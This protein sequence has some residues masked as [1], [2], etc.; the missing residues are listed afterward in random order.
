MSV[1]CSDIDR[2]RIMAAAQVPLENVTQ[3]TSKP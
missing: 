2:R 3:I 1:D